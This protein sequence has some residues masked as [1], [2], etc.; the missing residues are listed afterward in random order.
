[1]FDQLKLE[2][3]QMIAGSSCCLSKF[4]NTCIIAKERA[5]IVVTLPDGKTIDGIAWE[6]TPLSIAISLSKSLAD[7][8]VIAKVFV[9]RKLF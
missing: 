9:S 8:T 2:Y 7:R 1:M 6:T 4:Y 3:D 5:P